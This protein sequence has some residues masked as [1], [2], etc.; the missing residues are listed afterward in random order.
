M[1]NIKQIAKFVV[2]L[3][4]KVR[5]MRMGCPVLAGLGLLR[6]CCW[7]VYFCW[8]GRQGARGML[9]LGTHCLPVLLLL[10]ASPRFGW[11]WGARCAWTAAAAG[12]RLL[13]AAL[14]PQ[15]GAWAAAPAPWLLLPALP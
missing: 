7:Q 5:G 10:L 3:G 9:L 1:I 4:D 12:C 8:A 15:L 13:R 11:G 2:G 6:C 14:P